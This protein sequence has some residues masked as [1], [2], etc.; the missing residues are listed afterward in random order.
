MGRCYGCHSSRREHPRPHSG[1]GCLRGGGE[2]GNT[3]VNGYMMCMFWEASRLGCH[4][5]RPSRQEIAHAQSTMPVEGARSM[6]YVR[7]W[8]MGAWQVAK[9]MP[10]IGRTP[11]PCWICFAAPC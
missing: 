8:R 11:R 4:G 2:Q 10:K 5:C 7:V 6:G 9:L 3:A 1:P